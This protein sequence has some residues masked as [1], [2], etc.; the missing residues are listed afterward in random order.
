[1]LRISPTALEGFRRF[2]IGEADEDSSI[3]EKMY[4]NE[5]MHGKE[6]TEAMIRGTA[7]HSILENP[8]KYKVNDLYICDNIEFKEEIITESIK[9]VNYD[10]PFEVRGHSFKEINGET[11]EL[12]GFVDQLQG[13][14]I[15]EHKT[16]WSTFK[17]ED[18][19]NSM[20]WKMYLDMFEAEKINYKVFVL[21]AGAEGIKLNDIKVFNFEIYKGMETNINDFLSVFVTWINNKNLREYFGEK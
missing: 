10:F 3:T 11:I 4:I 16:K 1:M 15:N 9:H 12:K 21:Y 14:E 20:Q 8:A 2:V 19:Y 17:Y 5:I 13:L 18:Y 6:K 7:F